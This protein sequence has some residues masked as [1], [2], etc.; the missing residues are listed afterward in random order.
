M[1]KE[2]F[3]ALLAGIAR[4]ESPL[5]P[6]LAARILDEFALRER[7][8]EAAETA[9]RE[10]AALLTPGP[11]E[12]LKL[13]AQGLAYKEVGDRLGIGEAAVK[14]HMGEITARL[15]LEN[16]AQAVAYAAKLGLA[17]GRAGEDAGR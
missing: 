10:V 8:R 16:R 14:Y 13:V 11:T 9:D 3:L 5:S 1:D 6:G 17:K 4:G 15:R 7:E 2:Q 12:I